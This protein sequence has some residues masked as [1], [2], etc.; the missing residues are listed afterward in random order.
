MYIT[1]CITPSHFGLRSSRLE[2]FPPVVR[3]AARALGTE[4]GC[5]RAYLVERAVGMEDAEGLS[6]VKW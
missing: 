6:T 5:L 3:W 2:V 1:A 4:F